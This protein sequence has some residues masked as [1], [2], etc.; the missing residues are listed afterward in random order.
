MFDMAHVWII[1]T[2]GTPDPRVPRGTIPVAPVSAP[3]L[4]F[5]SSVLVRAPPSAVAECS[6]RMVLGCRCAHG[7]AWHR[8]A[9][10]GHAAGD[11]AVRPRGLCAQR[12]GTRR[13]SLARCGVRSRAAAPDVA[14]ADRRR[15]QRGGR[16]GG[17]IAGA[18]RQTRV[19]NLADLE[20]GSVDVL[21]LNRQFVRDRAAVAFSPARSPY[22]RSSASGV[23]GPINATRRCPKLPT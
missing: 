2:G 14:V 17:G 21:L 19:E 10:Y 5:R 22:R 4:R 8:A 20:L 3:G 7:R 9:D 6:C 12:A 13:P 11:R 15:H 1:G 16:H 18:R 23:T